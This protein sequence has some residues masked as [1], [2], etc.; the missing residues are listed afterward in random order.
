MISALG[1]L[2]TSSRLRDE[3]CAALVAFIC[4]VY[5][6]QT[7]ISKVSQL[8]W[9]MF[10]KKQVSQENYH[11]HQLLL[12]KQFFVLITRPLYGTMTLLL[13]LTFP[14][15]RAMGGH[16]RSMDGRLSWQLS[17]QH[18]SQC[19]NLW[20]VTA[21]PNASLKGALVH[22]QDCRAQ[23]YA[24]AQMRKT[25]VRMCWKIQITL[26]VMKIWMKKCR[27]T[28][29]YQ[30]NC[31]FVWEPNSFLISLVTKS[32]ILQYLLLNFMDQHRWCINKKIHTWDILMVLYIHLW[33][34]VELSYGT[35]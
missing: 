20:S 30:Q 23:I 34:K 25:P 27:F 12:N 22:E 2:G 28:P 1:A 26:K 6:S 8:R 7:P 19:C 14:L 31:G 15:L 24:A 35:K 16:L 3:N 33:M 29:D 17:S 32:Y 4:R 13:T 21:K 9:W 18:Q 11:L 10:M 5:I